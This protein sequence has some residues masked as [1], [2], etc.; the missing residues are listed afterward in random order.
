VSHDWAEELRAWFPANE[1][2]IVSL[3]Q[4]L[5]RQPSVPGAEEGAQEIVARELRKLG[6]YPEI[7]SI[8]SAHLSKLP[9][10]GSP[11]NL[12]ANRPIVAATR[13]G[14]GG[15]RSLILSAHID[16]VPVEPGANWDYDPWD[17]EQ[18]GRRVYGRGS[19]DDKAGVTIIISVLRA[20]AELGIEL[21]GDLTI[22]SVP[23]EEVGGRG[24][25]ALLSSGKR[26]DAALYVDGV[27]ESIVNGMMGQSWFRI[28]ID[29]VSGGAVGPDKVVNPIP[30]AARII[31]GLGELE[32][33]LNQ[34]VNRSY[35]GVE[36]PIRVNVGAVEAG[37]WSNS[38]PTRCTLHGQLNFLPGRDLDWAQSQIRS[39]VEKVSESDSWLHEHPPHIEFDGVQSQAYDETGNAELMQAMTL[40]HTRVRGQPPQVRQILGFVDTPLYLQHGIPSLCY[41]PRGGNPHGLNEYV[42]LDSLVSCA[43]V[44]GEF[45]LEWCGT[46]SLNS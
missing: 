25:L 39:V 32:E 37:V 45:V 33:T 9:G 8:D 38:I 24:T 29:G 30:L 26:A 46:H 4:E 42:D 10:L 15:G 35:G 12:S 34:E 36:R 7:Y 2:W 20:L 14:R 21:H 23:D 40:A 44:V 22:A 27:R 13:R 3:L 1:A 31:L 5:I 16:V 18:V 17:G 28:R 41:G 11:K 19:G 43:Q 6:V